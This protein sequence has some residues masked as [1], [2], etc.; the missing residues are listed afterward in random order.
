MSIS[1]R[2]FSN[3][4]K[5]EVHEMLD[6]FES[7]EKKVENQ[8]QNDKIFQDEIDRLLK[9]SLSRE[10]RDCVLISVEKQKNEILMLEKEKVSNDSKDIQATMEQRIK[11]LEN[12]LKLNTMTKLSDK[13]VLLKTQVE[14]VVQE[15]ENIKLEFQKQFNSI[16][17]TRVQYQ[18]EVNELVEHVNQKTY[19]YADVRAKNQDLLITIFELKAKLAA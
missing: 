18:Q 9:T 3:E 11:I 13:N 14:S 16:K 19:A 17:A 7:M 2:R 10:I 12:E 5:Q 6:I 15:R 4:I 8:S 1:L